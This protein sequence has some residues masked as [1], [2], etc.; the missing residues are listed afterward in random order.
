[1]NN[2]PEELAKEIQRNRELL[3]EYKKIPMGV[4]GAIM[5]EKDIENAINALAGGDVVEML[6]AYQNIKD[7]E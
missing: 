7:N 2:L 4:F 6:V 1:M 3:E 5:I